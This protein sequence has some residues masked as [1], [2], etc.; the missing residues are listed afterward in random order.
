MTPQFCRQG[1]D[2]IGALSATPNDPQSR[3]Y[4]AFIAALNRVRL[5]LYAVHAHRARLNRHRCD[6]M[7]A[8]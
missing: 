3:E 5:A 7:A 4:S 6:G 1:S 2:A 8:A